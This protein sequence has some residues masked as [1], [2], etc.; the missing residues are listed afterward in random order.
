MGVRPGT[1]EIVVAGTPY[2]VTYRIT[3]DVIEILTIRDGR[4]KPDPD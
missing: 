4:R 1:R 3:E 2:I